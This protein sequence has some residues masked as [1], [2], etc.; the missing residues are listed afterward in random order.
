MRLDAATARRLLAGV[1]LVNGTVA[2]AAPEVMLRRLGTDP[3]E[4]PSGIYPLR[5]FGVRTVLLAS[6]L[7]LLRGPALRR[8][9]L[10]GVVVHASDAVAAVRGGLSGQLPRR[11]ALLTTAVSTVN[12]ALAVVASTARSTAE[13]TAEE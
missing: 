6:D 5:M 8:A 12:T 7:V 13:P 4:D 10:V 9:A 1:R 3:D 2:L 11:V